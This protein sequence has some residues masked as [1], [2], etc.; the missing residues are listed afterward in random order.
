MTAS[1]R[2]GWPSPPTSP[3]AARSARAWPLWQAGVAFAYVMNR[4]D[5]NLVDD[6][7]KM[8]L[9]KAVYQSLGAA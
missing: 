3:G 4:M 2:C 9:I 1:S 6:H 8:A 5:M 7:R